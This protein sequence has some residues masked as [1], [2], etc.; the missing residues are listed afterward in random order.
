MGEGVLPGLHCRGSSLG[1]DGEGV[2]S[3]CLSCDVAR[4]VFCPIFP[5]GCGQCVSCVLIRNINPQAVCFF[6]CLD[7][8]WALFFRDGSILGRDS[9]VAHFFVG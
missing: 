8:S 6:F 1:R 4:K 7:C 3:E 5:S 2:A 9:S